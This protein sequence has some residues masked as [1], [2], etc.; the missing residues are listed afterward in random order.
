MI[1]TGGGVVTRPENRDLLRQN[2]TIVYIR[3]EM[4]KT[5]RE[6][7][8]PRD[9][10]TQN[11]PLMAQHTPEELEQQRLPLYV[12]WSDIKILNIGVN[13]TAW[14]LVSF[15]RLTSAKRKRRHK[16]HKK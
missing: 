15:L 2:G 16:K 7:L 6:Q 10:K 5:Y 12:E 3:R 14:Q 1:S 11:R 8:A 9:G 13:E 4:S